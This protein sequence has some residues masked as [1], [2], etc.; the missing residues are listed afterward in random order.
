GD[1][2][3]TGNAG[4]TGDT[5]PP[6]NPGPTGVGPAEEYALFIVSGNNVPVGG[7]GTP[8]PFD[9]TV[10]LN[11]SSIS[12]SSPNIIL[13]EGK[14]YQIQYIIDNSTNV[15]WSAS[16]YLDVSTLNYTRIGSGTNGSATGFFIVDIPLG[17]GSGTLSL[18]NEGAGITVINSNISIV[19]LT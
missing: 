11:G 15:A 1:T 19:A 13:E 18:R 16:L 3:P 8:I 14:T 10:V 5:G 9:T 17:S 6:G 4:L 7:G 2:G 12:L